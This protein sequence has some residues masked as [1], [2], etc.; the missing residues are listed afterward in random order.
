MKQLVYIT[1]SGHS[2]S[3][4]L[5]RLLG[6]H[7]DIAALGEVHRFSLGLHRYE[8]PFRC[9]CGQT[10]EACPFWSRVL[11]QLSR[12]SGIPASQ[13]AKSFRTT[14]HAAL[15]QSSGDR[16]FNA[17]AAYRF[18][19]TQPEKYVL[20]FTP[21]RF[22]PFFEKVGA[23]GDQLEFARNSHAVFQA[24]AS[25]ADVSTIVDSTKNPMRMRALHLTA[26]CVMK[27][28]YLRR[29][30]QAVTN[31]RMKRQGIGMARA[32]RIWVAENRK[33][34]I[35]L[36]AMTDVEVLNV[37]YE[38]LCTETDQEMARVLRFLDLP[39]APTD[40]TSD[41]HAIGGN[42]SRLDGTET[43]RLDEAWRTE[44]STSDLQVFE[45]IAG[46]E[47]RRVCTKGGAE[48]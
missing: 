28:I 34:R 16:Y 37:T 17:K 45:K 35:V 3:T 25:V 43:I 39:Q 23:L 4:L 18:L 15:K 9:D 1:G 20:G 27:V 42:P 7:P 13:I 24:V 32:A 48:S 40:L 19:P 41:R 5:D 47:Q 11:E 31:S 30:G 21:Q 6:S 38:A 12:D 10:I 2:G 14:D 46:A 29:D 26:P 44:L 8:Q 36:R 33:A 22:V